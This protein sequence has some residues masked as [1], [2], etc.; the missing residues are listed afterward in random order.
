MLQRERQSHEDP[1]YVVASLIDSFEQPSQSRHAGCA[2]NTNLAKP[3]DAPS[4]SAPSRAPAEAP[5]TSA[6][7]AQHNARLTY[8]L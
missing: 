5:M 3:V 2:H 8:A 7:A 1:L 6:A 4:S